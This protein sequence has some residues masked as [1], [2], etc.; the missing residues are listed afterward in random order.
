MR[1]VIAAQGMVLSAMSVGDYDKRVVLLTKELGKV[2]VFARGARRANSTLLASTR[3]F[4]F[5]T[6]F[7]YP[8]RDAYTLQSAEIKEYFAGLSNNME[9]LT[10]GCYFLEV[11]DYYT[12][13]GND[14]TP[15][16]NLLYMTVKALINQ[17]IENPLVKLIFELRAM[18]INGVYPELFH[19]VS[20]G[21]E[22]E[23][24]LF[25]MRDHGIYC[26]ECRNIPKNGIGLDAAAT[27]TLQYI[28]AAPLNKLYTFTLSQ[29]T[30]QTVKKVVEQCKQQYQDKSFHSLEILEQIVG[31]ENDEIMKKEI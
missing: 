28:I 22:V 7:L 23:E 10:Y 26:T 5:G 1:D 4:S 24:G 20:C 6:F 9:A 21:Q 18:T 30:I 29:K 11:A 2:A 19:C 12:R 8:G 31:R 13:E 3:P 14:E 25:S 17:K 16:L 15:M 27:Y